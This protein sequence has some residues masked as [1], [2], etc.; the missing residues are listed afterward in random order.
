RRFDIWLIWL[1]LASLLAVFVDTLP[2]VHA[3][4]GPYLYAVEWLFALIFTIEYG[5]RLWSVEHR[6]RYATSFFGI[7][8][9]LAFLATYFSPFLPGSQYLIAIRIFRVLRIFRILGL[10][11]FIREANALAD[12]L[13]ASRRKITVFLV[14][15]MT[16]IVV[17]GS[18]MY[19][20]EGP[21]N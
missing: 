6:I 4:F 5:F 19:L 17:A 20:I 1:I 12:A 18:L 21:E 14:T 10:T 8:D 13:R 16:L 15:V 9:L 2:A 3:R 7:V 11:T